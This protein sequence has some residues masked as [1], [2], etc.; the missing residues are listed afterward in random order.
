MRRLQVS[1]NRRFLVWDDGTPFFWLG[2]TAWE[3]FHRSTLE[4]AELYLENR[5]Q[6]GFTVI[7]AVALAE[8]NGL[9]LPNA[10]GERPLLENDPLQPN[11]KYFD[12]LDRVIDL[13]GRKG[14]LVGLLPTWGDKI[15][16][17]A[18]GVGPTVFNPVNALQ[19]GQWI[20]RRYRHVPN[21]VWINGGDRS[22][23]GTNQPVWDALGR[24]IKSADAN[25]LMT[26]HPPGGGD[27]HS[28]SEWFHQADWLDFNMAQSGHERKHLPNY[29][30]VAHDYQLTPVKPCL[31][32]E[33]RYEDHAVNWK[34]QDLSWFD[35]YDARQAAYWA[36][37][38]GAFGH[39]YGCHPIWQFFGERYAP[40][41][42]ARRYWQEALD[43]PGA[44]QMQHLRRLLESRPM[45]S[46]VPDPS[47]LEELKAGAE[48]QCAC[49][50]EDYFFVYLPQGGSVKVSLQ[51]LHDSTLQAS[52]YDPRTGKSRLIG[53][54]GKEDAMTFTAPSAGPC[55]DWVLV[56][57]SAGR[58]FPMPGFSPQ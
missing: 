51:A 11:E 54:F 50:G 7:Q 4:E 42:F 8:F 5:R 27:G 30:I 17:L 37:F 2:D 53:A 12:Y 34:P 6:K 25:H 1:P 31:D 49:R 41:S 40:V 29:Q 57:D 39:T 15:E 48:H 58:K 3:L 14:L 32:G 20:G 55:S 23:G 16:L 9:N 28:S 43:L 26:F 19:Y 46:R 13:A 24:G 44:F 47:I 18:H 52:W 33:P 21:L 56:V 36:L 22:G 38:A 45:L 10:S 35:D